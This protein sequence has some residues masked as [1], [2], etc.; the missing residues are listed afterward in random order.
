M[1]SR[2]WLYIDYIANIDGREFNW[3]IGLNKVKDS[4]FN[5]VAMS[6]TMLALNYISYVHYNNNVVPVDTNNGNCLYMRNFQERIQKNMGP[7]GIR[8]M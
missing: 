2:Y 4:L 7:A 1:Y 8:D 5:L 6:M 3:R